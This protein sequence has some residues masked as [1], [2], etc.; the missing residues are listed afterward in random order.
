MITPLYTDSTLSIAS[1]N[2]LFILSSLTVLISLVLRIDAISIN[3]KL[4]LLA[5]EELNSEHL[6]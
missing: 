5:T 2:V 3:L 4:N 6:A 1:L